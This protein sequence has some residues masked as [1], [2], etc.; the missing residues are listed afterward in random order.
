MKH[1][2]H[3]ISYILVLAMMSML[4]SCLEPLCYD[5]YPTA[6]VSFEWEREWERDY[7][8]AHS[9]NW[10]YQTYGFD[11]QELRPGTPEWVHVLHYNSHG[12]SNSDFLNPQGGKMI[13]D[14]VNDNSLLFYNGDT[15]YIVISDLA[16][17][18]EARASAT[19]RSR[20]TTS[21]VMQ[22]HPDARSTNP[23]DILYAA[24]I[25]NVPDIQMHE[26]R[27]LPVKM[28]PL[29]YTYVI[30]YEF[31]EGLEYVSLA[32][33]ALGGMA[34]SVYLRDGVTSDETS[35]ILY[36]CE[37]KNYGFEAHVRSFGVPGFPDEYY[38]RSENIKQERPYSLNLEVILKNGKYLTFDFDVSEQLKNQPRGGVITVSGIKIEPDI[39]NAEGNSGFDVNLSDWGNVEEVKLEI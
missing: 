8:K 2:K 15:E 28:Q 35:I 30:R 24:Y 12:Q 20:S 25:E 18:P 36:D 21:Y 6:D 10:D 3:S 34:E 7:G 31:E 33:G 27:A 17:L 23:P 29:V 1:L 16:Y 32:R 37:L 5:H 22:R 11:Y 13:V 39:G 14:K 9:K 38:G 4:T 19:S 26:V